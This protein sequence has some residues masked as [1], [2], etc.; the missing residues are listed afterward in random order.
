MSHKG[1][2]VR[3]YTINKFITDI[4]NI[5][6][7]HGT[8][9]KSVE[10]IEGQYALMLCIAQIGELL[11]KITTPELKT[12]LPIKDAVAFRNVIVHNYEH[13]NIK[14]TIRTLKESIPELKVKIASLIKDYE[15]T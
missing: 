11:N 12:S 1:D 13:L 2:I 6:K 3:L 5:I 9:E 7:N 8:I 4:E 14:F 15:K 10:N